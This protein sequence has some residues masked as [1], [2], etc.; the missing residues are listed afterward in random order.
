[1]SAPLT[2]LHS[3]PKI[4]V[5]VVDMYM[6]PCPDSVIIFSPIQVTEAPCCFF[7]VLGLLQNSIAYVVLGLKFEGCTLLNW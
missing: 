6:F 5:A 1:M 7:D 4:T 3:T 2:L